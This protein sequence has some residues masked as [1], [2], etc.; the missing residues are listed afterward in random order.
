MWIFIIFDLRPRMQ[1]FDKEMPHQS[2]Y[3]LTFRRPAVFHTCLKVFEVVF[4]ALATPIEESFTLHGSHIEEVALKEG[5][6][7]PLLLFKA[8]EPGNFCS[9]QNQTP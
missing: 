9:K 5:T 4:I 1:N 8:T 2:L 7:G 3:A 6:T